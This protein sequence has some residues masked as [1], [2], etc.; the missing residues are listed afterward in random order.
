MEEGK[1]R[2]WRG[3]GISNSRLFLKYKSVTELIN[4]TA[5]GG[6]GGREKKRQRQRRKRD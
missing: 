6:E 2:E 3:M 5:G 4:A 1:V